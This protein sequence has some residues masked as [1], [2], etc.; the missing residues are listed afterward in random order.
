MA[1]N[2]KLANRQWLDRYGPWAVVAGASTGIGACFSQQL[3]AKGLNLVMIA[4]GGTGLEQQAAKLEQRFGIETLA[5]EMDLADPKTV[6]QLRQYLPQRQVGLL[7]YVA[8][9]SVIGE[10]LNVPLADKLKMVDVNVRAPLLF[11]NELAP[12]MQRRGQGGILLMSSLSGFQGTA[13]VATYA[14][15]K[16][17]NTLLAEGLWSELQD[18]GVDVLAVVAGATHTPTF[19]ALTPQHMQKSVYPMEPEAVVLEALQ[20]LGH[21]PTH[22]VGRMNRAV[23]WVLQRLLSRAAAIRFISRN[24]KRVYR[25]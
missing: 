20:Q 25:G 9:H 13:M 12:A 3:A 14:A 8:C 4:L 2:N 7:A 5:L 24:T 18:D 11:I 22:I 10:F 23:H 6:E 17:F 21:K 15:T 1:N 19:D 16:A